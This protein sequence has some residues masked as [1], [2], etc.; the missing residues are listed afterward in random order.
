MHLKRRIK[1][2]EERLGTT[3]EPPS[4]EEYIRE[5]LDADGEKQKTMKLP[6]PGKSTQIIQCAA[7]EAIIGPAV[8]GC[9]GFHAII[10]DIPEEGDIQ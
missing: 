3:S 5:W 6:V 8:E 1:K 9:S 4:S 10:D 7:G 2:I